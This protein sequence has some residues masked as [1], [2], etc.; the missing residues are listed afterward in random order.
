LPNRSPLTTKIGKPQDV[1]NLPQLGRLFRVYRLFRCCLF[2]LSAPPIVIGIRRNTAQ[3]RITELRGNPELG[4]TRLSR[5]EL[6]NVDIFIS[7]PTIP[8]PS[9]GRTAS[10]TC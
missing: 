2:A 4:P 6:T 9:S 7:D 1:V 8:N 5:L 3:I 10:R